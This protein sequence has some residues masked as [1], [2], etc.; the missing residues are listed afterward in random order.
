M[1]LALRGAKFD[2]HGFLDVAVRAG[3]TV[4]CA[5]DPLLL[6]AAM[7]SAPSGTVAGL[8]AED[9]LVAFQRIAAWYRTTLSARVI[10]VTGSVG[11]TSTR[12]MVSAALSR[13]RIVHSTAANLN[14]EIGLPRTILD[15]SDRD[16][17]CVLEMGM[18]AAGEISLLSR[19]ATPDAVAVTNIGSAHIEFLGSREAILD[20][21]MEILHGLRPDGALF[22]N[23]DDPYL[24]G[25]ARSLPADG[26]LP[27]TG[28]RASLISLRTEG[29]ADFPLP[30]ACTTS[31]LARRIRVGKEG[32]F[33]DIERTRQGRAEIQ[34]DLWVPI[35]GL[36]AV[37]NALFAIAAADWEGVSQE[38]SASGISAF[39]PTGSRMKVTDFGRLVL[40]DD[41]YNASPE[42]MAAAFSALHAIAAGR[43]MLVALGGMNEL[44]T[45]SETEHRSTGAAAAEAGVSFAIATGPFAEAL[46][47]GFRMA[48][49]SGAEILCVPDVEILT[50]RILERLR[51]DDVLLVKGSR[52]FGM[53]RVAN[54]IAARYETT[55]EEPR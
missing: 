10:A 53:E 5:S 35:P 14:N 45:L 23:L 40:I 46:A 27:S 49:S 52:S 26:V 39:E 4:L 42:S 31:L 7:A 48:A 44:G 34:K 36:H 11:K 38:A 50:E 17:V 2:G 32:T 33:F 8:L 28:R 22:L 54:A 19:I 1:Y 20:A 41:S 37:R 55:K 18:R 43:R 6:A 3:V 47:D 21:K 24:L 16:E 15:A 9:T 51:E 25:F 12:D 29:C 30:H 13:E